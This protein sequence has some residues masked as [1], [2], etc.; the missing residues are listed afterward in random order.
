MQVD[1][2][3]FVVAYTGVIQLNKLHFG[4]GHLNVWW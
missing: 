4:A 3:S 1:V 2:C